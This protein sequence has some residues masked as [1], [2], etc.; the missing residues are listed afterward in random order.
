MIRIMINSSFLTRSEIC[1]YQGSCKLN[2]QEKS[3]KTENISA[4][5]KSFLC[6]DMVSIMLDFDFRFPC[7]LVVQN[8]LISMFHFL[9]IL[10]R[11]HFS[12][13]KIQKSLLLENLKSVS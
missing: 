6:N 2:T 13:H 10:Q 7:G 1:H 12:W 9:L 5:K 4:R 11:Q 3:P 8:K